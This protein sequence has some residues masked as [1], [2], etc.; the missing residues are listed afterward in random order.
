[1]LASETEMRRLD[2]LLRAHRAAF[3]VKFVSL[4]AEQQA[5]LKGK[6]IGQAIAAVR[7]KLIEQA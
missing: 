3:P 4:P 7:L 1:M 6:D 5:T 2:Q